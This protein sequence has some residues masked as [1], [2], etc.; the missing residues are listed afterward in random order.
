MSIEEVKAKLAE[1]IAILDKRVI[2]LTN[3]DKHVNAEMYNHGKWE[4]EIIL[5]MI[6]DGES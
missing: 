3:Q 2:D 5:S 4:L 6:K 1:R